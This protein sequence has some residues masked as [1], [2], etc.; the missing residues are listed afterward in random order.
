MELLFTP[1]LRRAAP[2]ARVRSFTGHES[3]S[4]PFRFVVEVGVRGR[5]AHAR[6][7]RPARRAG[8][9][10][11]PSRDGSARAGT[12]GIITSAGSRNHPR[13]RRPP[14]PSRSSPPSGNL[15]ARAQPRLRRQIPPRHP[16]DGAARRRP[17]PSGAFELRV[18]GDIDT[19][20][21]RLAV[22]RA[23]LAF[24]SRWMERRRALLLLRPRGS[25]ELMVVTDDPLLPHEIPA[26]SVG[27]T[28]M[29]AW[30]RRPRGP[31]RLRRGRLGDAA[32]GGAGR[33]QRAPALDGRRR[34][35]DGVARGDS[36]RDV[37]RRQPTSDSGAAQA[38]HG[39]GRGA[40]RRARAARRRQAGVRAARGLQ[41]SVEGRDD[42]EGEVPRGGGAPASSNASAD[43]STEATYK[44]QDWW[45]SLLGVPYRALL[46]PVAARAGVVG[47]WSTA[48][49]GGRLGKHER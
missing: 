40:H 18:R 2:E 43:G 8:H 30:R 44:G 1:H 38:R 39:C 29:G 36:G 10:H 46:A 37:T 13:R 35:R 24:V 41:F 27:F 49:G 6:P 7:R 4:R 17:P 48:H 19:P 28:P 11:R 26:E 32:R 42:V 15:S 34:E 31:L 5:R 21:P 45:R 22:P 3:I 14:P 47:R 25:P 20:S 23:T 16:H 33:L 12:R 9:P